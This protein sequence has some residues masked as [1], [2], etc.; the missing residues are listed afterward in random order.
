[1]ALLSSDI[2]PI[3]WAGSM[4]QID[5]RPKIIAAIAIISVMLIVYTYVMLACLYYLHRRKKGVLR[6]YK[7]ELTYL[8]NGEKE[9][10]YLTAYGTIDIYLYYHHLAKA[11]IKRLRADEAEDSEYDFYDV[12]EMSEAERKAK[13][14]RNE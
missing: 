5:P 14:G 4:G 12:F 7:T 10:I 13:N 9:T 1:M 3:N 11:K 6:Y 2:V 8:D